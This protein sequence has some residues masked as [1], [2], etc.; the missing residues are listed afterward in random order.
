MCNKKVNII[1]YFCVIKE[2]NAISCTTISN[3][4]LYGGGYNNCA[5][6]YMHIVGR[7]GSTSS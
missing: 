4:I 6:L 2:S 5:V 7:D 3:I 1:A